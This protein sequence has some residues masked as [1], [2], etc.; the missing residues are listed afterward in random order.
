M[1][2][3]R[4]VAACLLLLLCVSLGLSSAETAD[5]M[6]LS[7]ARD[8]SEDSRTIDVSF[9]EYA[10]PEVAKYLAE[11]GGVNIIIDSE[12][13]LA[14]YRVTADLSNVTWLQ[15]LNYLAEKYEFDVERT[16]PSVYVLKQPRRID[17]VANQASL[18]EVIRQ[19][20]E[21]LPARAEQ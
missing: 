16:S 4:T 13:E 21:G 8:S 18:R 17:L 5:D 7:N 12:S 14:N 9:E 19:I 1:L 20:A 2:K 11:K 3:S 15:V 10:L 6:S